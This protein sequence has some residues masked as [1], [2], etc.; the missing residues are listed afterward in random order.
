MSPAGFQNCYGPATPADS[1]FSLLRAR[2]SIPVILCLYHRCVCGVLGQITRLS[3]FMSTYMERNCALGS[4]GEDPSGL[5][6]GASSTPYLDDLDGERLDFEP[7]RFR[8]DFRLRVDAIMGCFSRET[9][10]KRSIRDQQVDYERRNFVMTQRDPNIH[11]QNTS[12]VYIPPLECKKS[13][14]IS[15]GVTPQ[16]YYKDFA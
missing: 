2:I 14:W 13:Q 9:W 3:G 15:W 5:L 4:E 8:W 6:P 16:S 12:L 7:V 1:P 10:G 11:P